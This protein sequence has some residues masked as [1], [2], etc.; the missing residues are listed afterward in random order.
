MTKKP[1]NSQ[2]CDSLGPKYIA[3]TGNN[4]QG[5]G[6][7][8]AA[9]I[10]MT[11]DSGERCTFKHLESGLT[12]LESEGKLEVTVGEKQSEG[13]CIVLHTPNGDLDISVR[14]GFIALKGTN[15]VLDAA[16]SIVMK[17]SKIQIGDDKQTQQVV[18]AGQKIDGKCKSGNLSEVLLTNS[19]LAAFS[20]SPAFDLIK[21]SF[22]GLA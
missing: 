13:P 3:S 7:A 10:K 18:L 20:G 22:T 15:I 9:S 14:D 4:R 6:G 11:N 2:V 16:D 8:E 21:K 17:A 1:Q 5:V 19:V 12:R